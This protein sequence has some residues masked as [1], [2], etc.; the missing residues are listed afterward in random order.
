MRIPIEASLV[1]FQKHGVRFLYPDIWELEES[2]NNDD[3]VITVSSDGTC[4]WSMHILCGCPPPPQVIESCVAAFIEEYDD[5][6]ESSVE[7]QLAEM[8]A[9]ARDVQFSCFELMNTASLQSV[10]TTEFTLLVLWQG[11]DHELVEY[12]QLLESMTE[13]VRA[14]SLSCC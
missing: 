2:G 1:P 5:T 14:D 10:R 3:I 7:Q 13:S 6:E 8:P 4:F 9:C 11:T 12:R